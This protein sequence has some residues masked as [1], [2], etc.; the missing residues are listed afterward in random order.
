MVVSQ[1]GYTVNDTFMKALSDEVPFFQAMFLR[2]VA[3]SVLMALL[4][5]WMG[6]LTWRVARGDR[7]LMLLRTAA[8]TAAAF[9]FVSALFNMPIANATAILQVLPLTVAIAAWL[10]LGEPLGWKRLAAIAVGFCGVMLIIRPGFEGFTVWSIYALAAVLAVT[11][12]DLVTRRMSSAL[13]S[14]TVAFAGSLGVTLFAAIGAATSDWAPVS[15][16]AAAQ[17][18]GAVVSL[19]AGYLFAV[20]VMRVGE[21]D[22][23]APFRYA[24]LI[25]ALVLG[26]LVFGD[27]PDIL[28]LVGSAIVVGTGLYALYRE[29]A[30]R[31]RVL[32][33]TRPSSEPPAGGR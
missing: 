25:A 16:L 26:Y 17:L 28:T 12:R 9:F 24:S 1:A 32:G 15:P 8:E 20:M 19:I 2:G 10:F 29:T 23:I 27:W 30:A 22:F 3:V 7:L 21:I 14:L 11:V 4:A 18:G 5:L 31:R 13:P 33:P 6:Q